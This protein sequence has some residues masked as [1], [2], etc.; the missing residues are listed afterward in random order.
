[1]QTAQ[2][3]EARAAFRRALTRQ[4]HIQP[5][6]SDVVSGPPPPHPLGLLLGVRP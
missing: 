6:L 5:Y 2:A 4:S 1:M 3:T